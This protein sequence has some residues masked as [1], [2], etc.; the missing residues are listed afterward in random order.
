MK[1]IYLLIA[2]I[3]FSVHHQ[4]QTL[5]G[6]IPDSGTVGQQNLNTTI[7]ATNLFQTSLSPE[8]NIWEINLRK[9]SSV[10]PVFGQGSIN[11]NV[12]VINSDTATAM[13]SIPYNAD[14]GLYD[15][16]L[17]TYDL[18]NP[19]FPNNFYTVP[20]AFSVNPPDGYLT[21]KIYRDLN[22]NGVLDA[23][24][25]GI[26]GHPLY[27]QPGNLVQYTDA[28]GDYRFGVSNGT[29]TVSFGVPISHT[30]ILSS[31][32]SS[33]TVSIANNTAGALDFGVLDGLISLSPSVIYPGSTLNALVT[34]RSVFLT[35]TPAYGNITYSYFQH[36]TT[37]SYQYL[38][39]TSRYV[40]LDSVTAHLVYTVPSNMQAGIYRLV[41]RTGNQTYFLENALTVTHPPSYLDGLCYYD[42]NNNGVFD[43]GEPPAVNIR[44]HLDPDSLFAFSDNFG[45]FRFGAALGNHT[46]SYS[47]LASTFLIL[48][49][50]PSYNFTNT[51]NQSGFDFGFRSNLP[52]YSCDI[53]FTPAL[54]RCNQQVSSTITYQNKSNVNSDGSV[55]FIPDSGQTY[56]SS[57]PAH[58]GISGDTIFWNFTGLLP[59][60]TR[61]ISVKV[62]NPQ[63]GIV[64]MIS[65]IRA[66]DGFGVEQ[67]HDTVT[68]SGEIRCSWDP[69][70]KAATPQG[71]D[72]VHHYT[73]ISETL[74][75]LIRFQNTGNDTAFTVVIRDTI[76]DAL[77]LNTFEL[78]GSSH[79][80]QV[81]VD[82]NRAATFTFNNILLADSV[83]DEPNS[84]GYIRYRISP[85]AGIPDPTIIENTAYIYFDFNPAVVTN[86]AWNTMVLNIP[87]GLGEV[88]R[89]NDEVSFFPN[90]V[91]ATGYFS[92]KN[93]DASLH[94]LEIFDMKGSGVFKTESNSSLI[95]FERGD[96]QSGLYM[97]RLVNQHSGKVHTGKI[98]LQ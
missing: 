4:A 66:V 24:E 93:P 65:G 17:S 26:E 44:L 30:Y 33:Y 83:V 86:T 34:S 76:D 61:N 74:E 14:T 22:E 71:V 72:D 45:F 54:M 81:Q 25:P 98:S 75:Y 31:D 5:N 15:L 42:A 7:T 97:F 68:W 47:P 19:G 63:T 10:I 28:Q 79:N 85:N 37:P 11:L 2:G 67:F 39:N 69:N 9:G 49:T 90:P 96:L 91:T 12:N 56:I 77:D 51:G 92:I 29:Y 59:M 41:I 78:Q 94:R 48:T 23:S 60:E 36:M 52:D 73:L 87:V 58:S 53:L 89:L 95:E 43:S 46:L 13:F 64:T 18:F 16:E 50:A 32:S 3:L 62:H 6:I 8:G 82:Q 80:V 27:L 70:D 1:N 21:G 40:V 20:L 88:I 35:G 57:I 55:Y 38:I 84:H